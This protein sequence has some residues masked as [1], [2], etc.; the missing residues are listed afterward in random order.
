MIL[1]KGKPITGAKSQMKP[2]LPQVTPRS[3]QAQS[4]VS[5]PPAPFKNPVQLGGAE[6]EDMSEQGQPYMQPTQPGNEPVRSPGKQVMT[7]AGMQR[8]VGYNRLPNYAGRKVHAQ[9]DP[10]SAKQLRRMYPG[11]MKPYGQ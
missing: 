2:R 5:A 8:H 10:R 1:V 11:I 3:R 6:S 7:N 9:G 4:M